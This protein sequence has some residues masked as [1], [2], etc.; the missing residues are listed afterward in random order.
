MNLPE[1]PGDLS[2]RNQEKPNSLKTISPFRSSFWGLFQ[3]KVAVLFSPVI[4]LIGL[5]CEAFE[6]SQVLNPNDFEY[7]SLSFGES[8]TNTEAGFSELQW[9]AGREEARKGYEGK[10]LTLTGRF[11][12][13]DEKRFILIRY[14]MTCCAADAVPFNVI[15]IVDPECRETLPS[16]NLKSNWVKVPGKIQFLKRVGTE[17]FTVS[18]ILKP[19]DG[20]QLHSV[21]KLEQV[22]HNPYLN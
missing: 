16:K 18:L 17:D 3:L 5:P 1:F 15:C 6:E 4:F 21:I 7:P 8:G 14:K 10:I 19:K 12:P 13:H 22:P 2:L 20:E 9:V 11:V